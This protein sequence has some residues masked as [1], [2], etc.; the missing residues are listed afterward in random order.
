MRNELP[1]TVFE[2]DKQGFTMPTFPFVRDELFEHAR[3]IL[4]DPHIV[5]EGYVRES[6]LRS[7]LNRPPQEALTPHYKLLWKLVGLEIWYQMYI[8]RGAEGPGD[9]ESYYT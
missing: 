3:A 9:I 1:P 6:Y 8:V 4:N 2:K 7:L 5:R